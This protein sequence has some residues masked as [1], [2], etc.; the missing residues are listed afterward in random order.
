MIYVKEGAKGKIKDRE[1][2]RRSTTRSIVAT[3]ERGS[4]IS[5]TVRSLGNVVVYRAMKLPQLSLPLCLRSRSGSSS[6]LD[7]Q[8]SRLASADDSLSISPPSNNNKNFETS[9]SL[10]RK[11]RGF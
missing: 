2:E 11:S 7:M 5:I 10:S 8:P 3:T 6:P 9:L 4:E 1:R